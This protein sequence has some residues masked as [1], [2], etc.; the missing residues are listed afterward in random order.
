VK[1]E[2]NFGA[3]PLLLFFTWIRRER[4][5]ERGLKGERKELVVWDLLVLGSGGYNSFPKA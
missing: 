4:F 3:L 1:R 2:E 5:L